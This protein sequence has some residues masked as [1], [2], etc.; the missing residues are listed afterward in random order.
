[1]GAAVSRQTYRAAN[2]VPVRA[3]RAAPPIS[4]AGFAAGEKEGASHAPSPERWRLRRKRRVQAAQAPAGTAGTSL[5]LVRQFSQ[6]VASFSQNARGH[7]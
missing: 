2:A 6:G 4:A 1:M 7:S 5:A 3:G